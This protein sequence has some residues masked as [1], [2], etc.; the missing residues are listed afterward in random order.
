MD[1][2]R[3]YRDIST[4]RHCFVLAIILV[5][6]VSWP[7]IALA[8]SGE[9]KKGKIIVPKFAIQIRDHD[10]DEFL[11]GI[12]ILCRNHTVPSDASSPLGITWL[13]LPLNKISGED[14]E[15]E[16]LTK[17]NWCI[18]N[19]INLKLQIPDPS[20]KEKPEEIMLL[21]IER[22]NEVFGVL[23]PRGNVWRS[24]NTQ[25]KV[26]VGIVEGSA[27]PDKKSSQ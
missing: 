8:Q 3:P 11:P 12:Q 7:L 19:P 9:V 27:A 18:I 10:T 4:T 1:F 14:I 17:K 16:L 13:P 25:T 23:K 26:N 15:I 22:C 5:L 6:V 2:H 24:Q 20:I 21:R